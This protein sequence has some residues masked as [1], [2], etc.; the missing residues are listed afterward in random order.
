MTMSAQ[1]IVRGEKS[2]EKFVGI[3][4]K[5]KITPSQGPV[6]VL[7]VKDILTL[8]NDGGIPY[9]SVSQ[10]LREEVRLVLK[11]DV[12]MDQAE[13]PGSWLRAITEHAIDH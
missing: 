2:K 1:C 4:K 3:Y 12:A 11:L 7:P 13:R 10:D 6:S 8:T 9:M 5:D